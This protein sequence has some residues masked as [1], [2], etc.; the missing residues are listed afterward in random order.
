[1]NF[2]RALALFAAGVPC[3][4]TFFAEKVNDQGRLVVAKAA[5]HATI[6]NVCLGL[7]RGSSNMDTTNDTI[8]EQVKVNVTQMNHSERE[9]FWE[10]EFAEGFGPS[11]LQVRE[12]IL[13]VI[14]NCL[15]MC[16]DNML[17]CLHRNGNRNASNCFAQVV[18]ERK[19][20]LEDRKRLIDLRQKEQHS[21]AAILCSDLCHTAKAKDGCEQACTNDMSVCLDKETDEV[22]QQS[23]A[24]DY[25]DYDGTPMVKKISP[26]SLRAVHS[27]KASKVEGSTLLAG[28][29]H[30]RRVLPRR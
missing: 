25:K 11:F 16:R 22:C 2:P 24:G 30:L 18:A 29:N 4:H 23:L 21:V 5:G 6:E 20:A 8:E 19:V 12:P 28:G 14:E 15:P 3:G 26:K 7:C 17:L 10:E 1:M 9:P 27:K 13:P